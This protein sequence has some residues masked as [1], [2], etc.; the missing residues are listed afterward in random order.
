MLFSDLTFLYGFLPVVLAAVFIVPPG[1]RN[2][3]I[4]AAS[5]LF[6]AWG[7]PLYWILMVLMIV[8]GYAAGLLL[9][10]L[11]DDRR[12]QKYTACIFAGG[13]VGVL[14]FFKCTRRLPFPVG[15]SFY[16]FQIISCLADIC[17]GRG[18]AQ[19]RFIDFAMYI[20]M[21][22][23]LI[24]GPIVRYEQ[25]EPQL[26]QRTLSFEKI[27]YGIRRFSA[28]LAKK[29]ILA[30]T[31]AQL[32]EKAGARN[33]M[34]SCFLAAF[35]F[36]MQIYYDFSGYSDMA[37][38][39]GSMMGFVFPENFDYPYISRS[40]TEFWRRWHMTLG[41]WF[42]DYVYIPLGGN[43]VGKMRFLRNIFVVW[44]LTGF[45]HGASL[46]FILWG[47]YFGV[48]LVLEKGFRKT[49]ICRKLPDAVKSILGWVWTFF[50]VMAGF[51]LFRSDTLEQAFAGIGG[52]IGI[53]ASGYMT[54]MSFYLLRNYAGIL[55]CSVLFMFPAVRTAER[56]FG[57][58]NWFCV[59][60]GTV[61]L[62]LLLLSTAFVID[63]S[64]QP[65]L[66]FRF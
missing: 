66:Y 23:Q 48:L 62:L 40:V 39:L 1:K 35:G 10:R 34:L 41:T 49:G 53:T 17:R 65:F 26:V 52:M 31:L 45:W 14:V 8:S 18:R 55:I 56:K 11:A 30:D 50:L 58:K 57:E 25:M 15:I 51:V 60:E 33:D 16:T 32:V 61:C 21:F 28:G 43:R 59:L 37:I 46:N 64:F 24:A 42:R 44:F 54:D 12:R 22:P 4:L 2:V 63:S 27:S 9:E 13:A 7:E 38:G 19:R 3:V 6:Y 20:S 29:V 36:M 5:L 47:L